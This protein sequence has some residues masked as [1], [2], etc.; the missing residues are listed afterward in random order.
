MVD[1]GR[2]I[3]KERQELPFPCLAQLNSK[4]FKHRRIA[5]TRK[6]KRNK[7]KKKFELY[8]FAHLLIKNR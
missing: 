2:S 6:K 7:D 1:E 5:R 8:N 3:I 4:M